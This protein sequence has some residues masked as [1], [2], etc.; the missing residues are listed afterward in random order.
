MLLGCL[1]LV[2][3]A[4]QPPSVAP[5]PSLLPA[6]SQFAPACKLDGCCEGHG[7]VA[8]LQPD[9]FVMCTDGEPSRICDCH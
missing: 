7:Q 2:A 3:C 9:K 1:A 6:G 4:T 5:Q 8:Y